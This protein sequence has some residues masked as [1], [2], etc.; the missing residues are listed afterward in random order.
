MAVDP[1]GEVYVTGRTTSAAFP[2][3]PGAFQTRFSPG[4]ARS[5]P[6]CWSSAHNTGGSSTARYLARPPPAGCATAPPALPAALS[7]S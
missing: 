1:A 5:P 6:T 7:E 2:T 4:R 3:T